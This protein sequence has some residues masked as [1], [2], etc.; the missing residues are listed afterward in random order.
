MLLTV[1]E[2]SKRAG[3]A[4]KKIYDDWNTRLKDYTTIQNGTKMIDED[5]IKIY[6]PIVV[7][8]GQEAE[9]QRIKQDSTQ[10]AHKETQGNIRKTQIPVSKTANDILIEELREIIRGKET[11][12]E[13]LKE[14]AK[15]AQR[16]IDEKDEQIR[17]ENKRFTETIQGQLIIIGRQQEKIQ[18]L[19]APKQ[20]KDKKIGFFRR[21]FGKKEERDS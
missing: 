21:L 10:E 15:E 11:E 7:S 5:A 9:G 19:E 4:K 20:E 2:F 3:V 14:Q 13:E 16:R 1:A 12:I 18:L 8:Q 6:R 17:E